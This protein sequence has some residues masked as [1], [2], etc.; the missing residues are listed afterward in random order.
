MTKRDKRQDFLNELRHWI[1]GPREL[2]GTAYTNMEK[3]FHAIFEDE[4]TQPPEPDWTGFVDF[5]GQG[6]G[7]YR[8]L[9]LYRDLIKHPNFSIEIGHYIAP[10]NR[11]HVFCTQHH[12]VD[13]IAEATLDTHVFKVKN[14]VYPPHKSVLQHKDLNVKGIYIWERKTK[15]FRIEGQPI[16][17]HIKEVPVAL[18]PTL[19]IEEAGLYMITEKELYDPLPYGVSAVTLAD[20]M[21]YVTG[22]SPAQTKDES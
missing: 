2:Q 11:P 5:Y 4:E 14:V 12:L 17:L 7:H 13:M 18:S 6:S 1:K 20:V 19:C 21:N 10:T 22:H 3:A 16:P 8:C 9:G 15:D